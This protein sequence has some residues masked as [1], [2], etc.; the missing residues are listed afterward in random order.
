MYETELKIN[1][2]HSETREVIMQVH[3]E[4]FLGLISSAA[5]REIDQA[6]FNNY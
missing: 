5:C 3:S 2:S 6:D 4:E 1:A